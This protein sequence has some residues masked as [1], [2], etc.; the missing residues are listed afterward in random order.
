MAFTKYR[1]EKCKVCFST[2]YCMS[3]YGC[4]LGRLAKL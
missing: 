3:C 4:I 2:F 1:G